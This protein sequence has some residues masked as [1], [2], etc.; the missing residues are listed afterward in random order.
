MQDL[1]QFHYQILLIISQKEF[2]K[3]KCKDCACF[4][5]NE[6][7]EGNLIKYKHLSCHEDYSNKFDEELNLQFQNTFKFSNNDINAYFCC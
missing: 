2:A 7:V 1:W 4:L 5:E 6:S 3:T